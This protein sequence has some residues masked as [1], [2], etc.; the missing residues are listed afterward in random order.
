MDLRHTCDATGLNRASTVNRLSGGLSDLSVTML[1]LVP[2]NLMITLISGSLEIAYVHIL[3]RHKGPAGRLVERDGQVPDVSAC[4]TCSR[5]RAHGWREVVT[6]CYHFNPENA[7]SDYTRDMLSSYRQILALA[8]CRLPPESNSTCHESPP[9]W[10]I[11]VRNNFPSYMMHPCSCA[12]DHPV[13]VKL[14]VHDT[15][16]GNSLDR[17]ALEINGHPPLELVRAHCEDL[18]ALAKGDV[19]VV[20]LVENGQAVVSSS[21]ALAYLNVVDGQPEHTVRSRGRRTARGQATQGNPSSTA[22]A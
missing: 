16:L 17:H 5:L 1:S 7:V 8:S 4:L 11:P 19:R 9:S 21:S 15:I 10:H 12:L 3:W 14:N 13:I 2:L 18:D 20:V 22:R 6:Y